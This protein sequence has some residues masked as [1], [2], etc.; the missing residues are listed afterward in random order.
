MLFVWE[1]PAHGAPPPRSYAT[2]IIVVKNILTIYKY[3]YFV[4]YIQL[5]STLLKI[6]VNIY[7]YVGVYLSNRIHTVQYCAMY[8]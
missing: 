3:R 5:H 2:V 6:G 7:K 1:A 4:C 8:V